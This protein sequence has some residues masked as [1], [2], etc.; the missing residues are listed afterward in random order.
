MINKY[1]WVTLQCHNCSAVKEKALKLG[2]WFI[3]PVDERHCTTCCSA[4]CEAFALLRSDLGC[5]ECIQNYK[6]YIEGRRTF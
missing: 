4:C 3:I 2:K 6:D 5:K 1:D